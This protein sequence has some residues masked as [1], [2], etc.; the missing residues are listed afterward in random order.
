MNLSCIFLGHDDL[1][2]RDD[3]GRYQLVCERCGDV[4]LI[5]AGQKLKVRREKR[6][7][8]RPSA[9]VLKMKRRA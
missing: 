2:E 6:P 1:R 4:R 9:A 7:R 3:Q 5:L 8:K